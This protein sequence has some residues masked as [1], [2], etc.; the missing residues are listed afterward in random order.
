MSFD[1][2][3]YLD[4]AIELSK[5]PESP[6]LRELDEAAFRSA[7]SRAYYATFHCA[8]DLASREGFVPK[9]TGE[10]H[11]LV[12][13][14]FQ[15]HEAE[16]EIHREIARELDLLRDHRNDVDY[17]GEFQA[18]PCNKAILAIGLARSILERLDSVLTEGRG[19]DS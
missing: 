7:A 1:W 16:D 10:D 14:H 15:N 9:H 19:A 11:Y 2:A 12:W 6:D 18:N 5:Q 3:D 8:M 4:F 13:R 17:K